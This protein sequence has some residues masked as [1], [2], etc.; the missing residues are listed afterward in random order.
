MREREREGGREGGRGEG[1]K[2][3]GRGEREESSC[4][5]LTAGER[6]PED[7]QAHLCRVHSRCGSPI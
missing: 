3:R 2:E 5:R 6:T 7:L 4:K 1:G